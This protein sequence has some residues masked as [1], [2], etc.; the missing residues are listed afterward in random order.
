VKDTAQSIFEERLNSAL[1]YIKDPENQKA[2]LAK[3]TILV[4]L[5]KAFLKK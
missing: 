4:N 2:L 1:E 3:A 5:A